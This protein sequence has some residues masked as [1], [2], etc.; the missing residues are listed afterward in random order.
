M[1]VA[2]EHEFEVRPTR[3]HVEDALIEGEIVIADG[4]TVHE[5]KRPQDEAVAH[6]KGQP[7]V[8]RW[9]LL[10]FDELFLHSRYDR[11]T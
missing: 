4:D 5:P 1:V 9:H 2:L 10:L 6:R 7:D 3:E 11:S 8:G